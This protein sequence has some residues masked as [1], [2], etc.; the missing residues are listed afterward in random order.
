MRMTLQGDKCH[1][2]NPPLYDIIIRIAI[3]I[4][5]SW[6]HFLF[7]QLLSISLLF[8]DTLDYRHCPDHSIFRL[9]EI[10]NDDNNNQSLWGD[11]QQ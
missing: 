10:Q 1:P 11:D 9:K 8:D 2:S 6:L 4:P 5:Y 3:C 7:M